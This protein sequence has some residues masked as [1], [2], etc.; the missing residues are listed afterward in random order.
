MFSDKARVLSRP[1]LRIDADDVQCAHGSTIGQLN[2]EEVHYIRSRGLQEE[3][4]RALLTY[5]FAEEIIDSIKDEACKNTLTG[6]IKNS[7][8]EL[9]HLR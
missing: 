9:K 6:L 8:S 1:Q 2:P 4:A 5:G 3:E 7:V